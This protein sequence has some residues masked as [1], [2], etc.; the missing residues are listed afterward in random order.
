MDGLVCVLWA[1]GGWLCAHKV[2]EMPEARSLMLAWSES[3]MLTGQF[4][5]LQPKGP[6]LLGTPLK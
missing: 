6:F 1:A 3:A 5:Q 2:K 4:W